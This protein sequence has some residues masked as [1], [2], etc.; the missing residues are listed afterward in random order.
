M[1]L[2]ASPFI[3]RPLNV[4]LGR[5]RAVSVG[6]IVGVTA[7]LFT[8][9]VSAE[10]ELFSK[11]LNGK[12][13]NSISVEVIPIFEDPSLGTPYTTVNS[14]KVATS[15]ATVR[16]ELIFKEGDVFD[17]FL[18]S[19][20]LRRLRSI[21]YLR[22]V[23]ITPIES[24][25]GLDIKVSVQDTWT[26]IPQLSLS[27][28]SGRDSRSF[29]FAESN[30]FG[31]GKRAEVSYAK[32]ESRQ[33]LE[34]VYEDNRV[35]GGPTR[36]VGGYFHRSDGQET[37]GYYGL[38]FRTLLDPLSWYGTIDQNDSVGR[39][40]E[41]G[42]ESYIFRQRSVDFSMRYRVAR[43]DQDS[44]VQRFTVGYDYERAK[45]YQAD[46]DDYED[47]DLD[48]AEVSNDPAFLA[49]N[50]RF[51]GPNFSYE[52]I[53]PDF[54]SMTYID[55][56]ERVEDYNLGVEHDI[57]FTIAPEVFGSEQDALLFSLNRAQGHAFSPAS[58]IR[59]EI[60]MGGRIEDHGLVNGL[61]RAEIKFYNV[62]GDS[63]LGGWWLGRHTF[64]A[65]FTAEYGDD[66]DGDRQ[67]NLG[68]DNGLRGYDARSFV[69]DKRMVLNLEDRV[70]LAE[71]VFDLMSFGAAGFVDL[72]GATYDT[73]GSI[74]SENLNA[75]VGVGL[76]FAFPRS[77]GGRVLR[78]DI[79]APLN[80]GPDGSQ[81][82]EFRII[83]AGGQIFGSKLR[84]EAEGAE[85]ANVSVGFER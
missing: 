43:N 35:F 80:D 82:L 45:F 1:S 62:L 5:V 42:D 48:P 27:S 12:V 68:A 71:N 44:N 16:Q 34:S 61:T 46:L 4:L 85:K 63:Y 6:V 38:P 2:S 64:A 75:D 52:F 47:L 51:S 25:N 28:G 66:L 60:G 24:A 17:A 74:L 58:F 8:T 72:G 78:V 79:A 83:F 84:S 50:R 32:E 11:R 81:S 69:G 20:A 55:R 9:T 22:N 36:F 39:L 37:I 67:L 14:I 7:F 18:M 31:L 23:V 21:R 41:A 56:F 19:E 3:F 59:G 26:L 65:N 53:E 30:L 33:S 15:E 54:I 10:N 70:H 49:K 13:I 29:G 76:R 40:F 77:S 57:G 73:L